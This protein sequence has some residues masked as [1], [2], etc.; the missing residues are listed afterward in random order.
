M[1]ERYVLN[2]KQQIVDTETGVTL[3]DNY[4]V[5]DLLNL[6]EDKIKELKDLYESEW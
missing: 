1:S 4:W 3:P 2:N 6:K 5:V